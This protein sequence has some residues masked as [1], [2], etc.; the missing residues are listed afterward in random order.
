MTKQSCLVTAMIAFAAALGLSGA[1]AQDLAARF[2]VEDWDYDKLYRGFSAAELLG[3]RVED[4]NGDNIGEIEDLVIGSEGMIRQVIIYGD[5]DFRYGWR[6]IEMA[7]RNTVVV[8]VDTNRSSRLEDVLANSVRNVLGA[9]SADEPLPEDAWR[10]SEL[11]G[12]D[13]RYGDREPFG[14][15]DD[16]IFSP[17]GRIA[18]VVVES[19]EDGRDR[20]PYAWPFDEAA[21]DP[22]SRYYEVPFRLRDV[23]EELGPFEYEELEN[24]IR[25]SSY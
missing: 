8:D 24:E 16:V 7:G 1:N 5:R 14:Q 3:A 10:L 15:I 9:D 25:P 23:R 21:F 2:D 19:D 13:A 20:G 17:S 12:D 6:D 4:E 18:A 22:S 11:L